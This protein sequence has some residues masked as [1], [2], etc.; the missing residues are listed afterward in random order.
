MLVNWDTETV[1]DLLTQSGFHP[2]LLETVNQS[3]EIRLGET[4]IESWFST[5]GGF[6]SLL[7]RRL[8]PEE[9]LQLEKF[10][11]SRLT[12]KLVSWKRS[13]LVAA[14]SVLN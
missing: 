12:G 10:A 9:S 14:G 7:A 5:E 8:E 6:G 2:D 3:F 4:R 11:V 1:R 13:Y